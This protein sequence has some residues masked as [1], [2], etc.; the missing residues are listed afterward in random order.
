MYVEAFIPRKKDFPNNRTWDRYRRSNYY[1][2][3][4]LI[5]LT[6]VSANM[7]SSFPLGN[8]VVVWILQFVLLYCLWKQK[9]YSHIG[10]FTNPYCI[11]GLY[12]VWAIIGIVRGV[13]VAENYWEYKNLVNNSLI[14]LFPICV[15]AFNSPILISRVLQTWLRYAIPAFFLFFCWVSGLTQFYLGPIFFFI[16]FLPLVRNTK[17]KYLLLIIGLAL[18][19]YD[20]QDQRSQFIKALF[21][22]LIMLAVLMRKYLPDLMLRL[23]HALLHILPLVLLVLGLLGVF[24]IFSDTSEVYNGKF[25]SSKADKDGNHVDMSADT[26]TF[27]YYEVITSAINNN[28]VLLGRTPARGNDTESFWELADDLQSVKKVE[29][30]KHERVKNELCFLNIFTWLGLIGMLLYIGIYVTASY[31]GVYK[32]RNIYVKLIGLYVAFNFVYGW[33]ENT[34]NFDILNFNYWLMISIC[35]STKFRKMT[36]RSFEKWMCRIFVC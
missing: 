33:V 21:S 12:L 25:L 28:Y 26:R 4:L 32:S 18:L 24:N 20:I 34:T 13:F 35:L 27:I 22:F 10:T 23:A 31:L 5:L 2:P 30:I 1:I 14:L 15:Y 9:V 6:F 7:Q 11:V 17:W 19:S 29:N 16:C 8:T 36:D 3:V